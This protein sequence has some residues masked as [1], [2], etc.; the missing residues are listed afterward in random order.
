MMKKTLFLILFLM[1]SGKAFATVYTAVAAGGN[2]SADAT[3]GGG[4]HPIAGDTANIDATMTGTVTIDAAS[5]CSVLN[6]TGNGGTLAF[7]NNNL[8]VTSGVTLGGN[9]TA[10]TGTL[11]INGSQ[12]LTSGGI[13]FPGKLTFSING[14]VTL[15]GNWINTGL[16]TNST[17]TLT[18]NKTTAETITC[19]G[20][21]TVSGNITGTA[22]I[23]LGGGTLSRT[24]GGIKN[25][26][27]FNGNVTVSGTIYYDT[28]T[29]TY[30]SGS[31]TTTGSELLIQ[32]AA[33]LNTDGIIWNDIKTI[34]N[35]FTLTL[36]SD[37][38]LSGTLQFGTG[39]TVLAGSYNI[40]CATLRILST[41]A[42]HTITL[43][44]GST[45]TVT[46]GLYING[47]DT[48]TTTIKSSV[49][50]SPANLIFSGTTSN[51]VVFLS[52]FTDIDASGSSQGIDNWYGGTLTRT[53]NITNRTS[54]DIGGTSSDVFGII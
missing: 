35:S 13:T 34:S 8:T 49:A 4:G 41:A 28:G 36:S 10:G 54:A 20:G 45:I 5:A 52:T 9:I 1:I 6:L 25:S 42:G 47:G 32:L 11:I 29:M 12:T 30:V 22:K 33:T 44:S 15:S 50:S 17:S 26:L 2:W 27:D 3:W 39:S 14:T 53:T 46:D 43:V 48:L 18:L 23:I 51:C 31:V 19:N 16:V 21:F 38:T 37:L 24:I 40:S 7:G